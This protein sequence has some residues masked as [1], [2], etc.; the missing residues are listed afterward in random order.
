MSQK[1]SG[2]F[3]SSG[4][5]TPTLKAPAAVLGAAFALAFFSASSFAYSLDAE[6]LAGRLARLVIPFESHVAKVRQ[7]EAYITIPAGARF[8]EGALV[9]IVGPE[10]G[11]VAYGRARRVEE[12]YAVVTITA[13]KEP[14]VPGEARARGLTPP[15]RILWLAERT[16]EGAEAEALV[17][18]EEAARGRGVFDLPPSDVGVF[19]L[20]K[21]PGAALGE[22]P[23]KD[24]ENLAESVRASL[25]AFVRAEKSKDA[26]SLRVTILAPGGERLAVVEDEWR[27]EKTAAARKE[28]AAGAEE[29]VP[30]GEGAQKASG[31]FLRGE[32]KG[33]AARPSGPP[34]ALMSVRDKLRWKKYTVSGAALS[35]ALFRPAP[36]A[37]AFLAVAFENRIRVYSMDGDDLR[38]VW[39]SAAD[40][41]LEIIS[42]AVHDADGSEGQEIFVNAHRGASLES[43]IV[44][45]TETGFEVTASGVPYYFSASSDGSLLAQRGSDDPRIVRN[46]VYTVSSSNGRLEFIPAFALR[47]SDTPIGLNRLDVDGD[48]TLEIVGMSPRGRLLIFTQ[49]GVLAWR[50]SG[51]GLTGRIIQLV[52]GK[53]RTM[54]VPVPPAPLLLESVAGPVLA[55]GGAEYREGGVFGGAKLEKGAV[56]FISVK[57]DEY[58]IQDVILSAEGWISDFVEAPE[59]ERDAIGFIRARPGLVS[60]ESEIFV[61]VME[62]PSP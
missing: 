32:W 34:V 41:G 16:E 27:L 60:G 9:R 49:S 58:V 25:V 40:G 37:A 29:S 21:Y 3:T 2:I 36:G 20:E 12:K 23:R 50:G 59:G 55:V 48:G 22:I 35:A 56:K 30:G 42:A 43:F 61:P 39:E 1:R 51:F 18:L 53:G 28:E 31:G 46:E 26:V 15:V 4:A 44:Q 17:R 62:K 7:G 33:G 19:F 13:A 6:R 52:I 54:P 5:G 57:E 38:P 47:G 14:I 24:I 8:L 10:G 11:A 45:L